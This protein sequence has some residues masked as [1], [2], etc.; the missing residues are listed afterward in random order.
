[1]SMFKLEARLD[2]EGWFPVSLTKV[3]HWHG[4]IVFPDDG[5]V[6]HRRWVSENKKK[7]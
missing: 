4:F 1:M 3:G 6:S 2:E 5:A 7:R